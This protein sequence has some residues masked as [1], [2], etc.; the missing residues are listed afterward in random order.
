MEQERF[1]RIILVIVVFIILFSVISTALLITN[2]EV[3]EEKNKD[4]YSKSVL[5]DSNKMPEVVSTG[6][7]SLEIISKE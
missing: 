7:I 6:S 5:E 4:D 3:I 1:S 2:L